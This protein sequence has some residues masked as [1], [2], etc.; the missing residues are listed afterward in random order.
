MKRTNTV[1]LAVL[2]LCGFAAGTVQ[3]QNPRFKSCSSSGPDS[4]GNMQACFDISGLGQ[5][6]T[7]ITASTTATATYGCLNKGGQCPNAQN[8]IS[9]TGNVTASGTFTPDKNGRASG[10]LTLTPPEPDPSFHCPGGQTMVLI[11]V[12]YGNITLSAPNGAT[13]TTGGG[14]ANFYP[15]CP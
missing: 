11:A 13:C 3:A 15:N 10:C 8:K 7:Q 2:A 1:I 12:S 4:S 6:P 14:S 9:A 5:T